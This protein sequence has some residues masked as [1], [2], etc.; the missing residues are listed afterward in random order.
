ML[1]EDHQSF[2]GFV[3][4]GMAA[5]YLALGTLLRKRLPADAR[6]LFGA[7]AMAVAFLT[8]AVPL[9]LRAHGLTLAWAVEGPVLLYLGYRFRY[10]PVRGLGAAVLVLSI[11]RLFA[12]HWPLHSG[13][14]VPFA[15]P[16]FVSAIAVPLSM[17]AFGLIHHRF[18]AGET[19]FDRVPKLFAV[20][21]GGLLA[22]IVLHAEIGDWLANHSGGYVA[23]CAV[24]VLWVAG[25]MLYLLGGAKAQSIASWGAGILPLSVAAILGARLFGRSPGY[26]HLLFLNL[27]FVSCLTAVAAMLGCAVVARRSPMGTQIDRQTIPA[28]LFW[29]GTVGLLALLSAEVYCYCDSTRSGQMGISLVWGLY[30]VSMLFVGFWRRRRPLRLF[31]LGLFALS[32]LKLVVVDMTHVQEIYRVVSFLGLGLLM[33]CA[34]YLYHKLEKRLLAAGEEP[35]PGRTAAPR[36]A[37]GKGEAG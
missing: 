29:S 2:L 9:H 32:A 33:V 22:L 15:N 12:A 20:L 17:A 28:A 7:I 26:A 25:A 21:G 1:H 14:F 16:Q 34:S 24:T 3:A 35:T 27:R 11:V 4:L 5:A 13:P 37:A 23:G 6:A 8:L 19:A 10:R 18:R 31:A 36:E 30:A